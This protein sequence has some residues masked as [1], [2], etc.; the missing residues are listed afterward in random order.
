VA[1]RGV[2]PAPEGTPYRTLAEWH[3]FDDALKQVPTSGVIPYDVIAPLF[4]D[5]AT[6]YRFLYV[7]SGEKISYS[8]TDT[9]KFPVG[10]ILVKTFSYLADARDPSKGDRLLETRLLIRESEGWVAHTYVWN[11]A[12]TEA[13]LTVGG[14]VID[15]QF[16]DASGTARTNQYVVPSENDCRGCHGPLGLTDTLGGRTLQ[17]DRDHDYGSGPENQ[18][19][20]LAKLGLFDAAPDPQ[21]ERVHLVDPFGSAP[22]LERVRSYLMGNCSHCHRPG[23]YGASSSGLWLDY[24]STDPSQ[25]SSNMGL[26]KQPTS[27]GGATCG[28]FLDVV[29]G[30]PEQSILMCR[31]ESTLAKVKM[32]PVGRMMV[33]AEGV[34]LLSDWI[35]AL[36]GSCG[37]K[38]PVTDA[39]SGKTAPDSGTRDA[40]P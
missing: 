19:D 35:S 38:P 26:C 36:P 27:A 1:T 9:W 2:T 32:P 25:P 17:L 29:P 4:S 39:G 37:E 40:G 30:H 23:K 12:Q 8:K 7:P 21:A 28:R 24:A 18:I 14:T 10:T 20:H 34:A 15:S 3:L 31:I 13:T 5:Y 11:E 33:H 22:R 6:K 16:V